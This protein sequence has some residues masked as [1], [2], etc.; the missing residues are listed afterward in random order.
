MI[1]K[2]DAGK[3]IVIDGAEGELDTIIDTLKK[4]SGDDVP[5]VSAWL[6]THIQ[7]SYAGAL[8]RLCADDSYTAKLNVE[9][10]YANYPDVSACTGVSARRTKFYNNIVSGLAQA[11]ANLGCKPS[12]VVAGDK[13]KVDDM[14]IEILR[15]YTDELAGKV[16]INNTGMAFKISSEGKKSLLILGELDANGLKDIMAKCPAEKLKSNI[17]QLSAGTF[18]MPDFYSLVD[19]D[20]YIWQLSECLWYSDFGEG[21]NTYAVGTSVREVMEMAGVS[22]DNVHFNATEIISLKL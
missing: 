13:I 6:I 2:T 14:E 9:N 17:V 7:P 16:S 15:T 20:E 1:V 21:F 10:I 11:E 12:K 22:M 4:L 8:A 19:P 5:T 18:F 3:L